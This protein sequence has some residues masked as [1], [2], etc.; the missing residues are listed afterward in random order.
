MAILPP[1]QSPLRSPV[2]DYTWWQVGG[3]CGCDVLCSLC[4]PVQSTGYLVAIGYTVCTPVQSPGGCGCDHCTP[5]KVFH[6]LVTMRKPLWI[7]QLP[8]IYNTRITVL[9][10][11]TGGWYCIGIATFSESSNTEQT[12][13]LQKSKI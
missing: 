4:T 10:C 9:Q 2:T 8:R 5:V 7:G 6:K 13:D 11:N 12:N 1:N 3:G